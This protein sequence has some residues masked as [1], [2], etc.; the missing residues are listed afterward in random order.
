M[1]LCITADGKVSALLIQSLIEDFL[2]PYADK[3]FTSDHEEQDLINQILAADIPVYD[4]ARGMFPRMP[5]DGAESQAETTGAPDPSP[6]KGSESEHGAI[7]YSGLDLTTDQ[8]VEIEKR[9]M[10]T[11]RIRET[12]NLHYT[13]AIP[14]NAT[15][16]EEEVE[17]PEIIKGIVEGPERQKYWQSKGGKI[18]LA[19][20]SKPRP[21]ETEVYLT[22]EEADERMQ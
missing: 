21:G 13:N 19:R 5:L 10:A 18:R 11:I 4:L 20:K 8:I 3:E 1:L 16:K 17:I 22:Q 15:R 6:S 9:I 7:D 2:A 12:H 14:D